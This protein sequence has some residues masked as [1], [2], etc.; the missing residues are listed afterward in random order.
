MIGKERISTTRFWYPNEAPRSVRMIFVFPVLSTFSAMFPMS[1]GERNCAF[2]TL[3]IRPVLPA[4]ISRSVCRARNAGI[5]S[6]SHTSAAGAAWGASCMSVSIGSFSSDLIFPRIRKPSFKP[7]PR[8]AFTEDRL[9]LSYEA[10]KMYGTPASPAILASFS[11]IIRACVSLSITHGPAIRNSGFPPPRRKEPRQISLPAVMRSFEDS[12]QAR[13][14]AKAARAA[15]DYGWRGEG[16]RGASVLRALLMDA[17]DDEVKDDRRFDG[18]RIAAPLRTK[19]AEVAPVDVE[20]G[21]KS[22][23]AAGAVP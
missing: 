21:L 19:N 16:Q 10:L 7:G 8:K 15:A 9:A 11:A 17:A 13:G 3:I 6:T 5:C 12:T 1:H 20:G 14:V 22:G 2:F 4:A 23:A 18:Q